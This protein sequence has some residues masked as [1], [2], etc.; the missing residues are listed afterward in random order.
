VEAARENAAEIT[1]V[2]KE[3]QNKS[4]EAAK[5]VGDQIEK[6]IA[7]GNKSLGDTLNQNRSVEMQK[8]TEENNKSL[9]K[10]DTRIRELNKSMATSNNEGEKQRIQKQLRDTEESRKSEMRHQE[11]RVKKAQRVAMLNTA[12]SNAAKEFVSKNPSLKEVVDRLDDSNKKE[13]E[14]IS[15]LGKSQ[16]VMKIHSKESMDKAHVETQKAQINIAAKK[17]NDIAAATRN[18]LKTDR[19]DRRLKR[20]FNTTAENEDKKT[21]NK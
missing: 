6:E 12:K 21:E 17:N 4:V 18:I 7:S 20:L 10:I 13:D 5:S 1:Q 11:D 15:E 14:A 19:E 9:G 16:A 8:V 2:L 3:N